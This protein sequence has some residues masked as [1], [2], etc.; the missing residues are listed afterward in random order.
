MK[1]T[2]ESVFFVIV[3]LVFIVVLPLMWLRRL[4]ITRNKKLAADSAIAEELYKQSLRQPDYAAFAAHYGCQPPPPLQQLYENADSN[5]EGDFELYLP[6]FPKPFFIAYFMGIG[7]ENMSIVRPGTEGFFPFA[8]DGCGNR[9][10]VNPREADP[11]V[12]LYDHEIHKRESLDV[13][14]SKF[15]AAKR[16]KADRWWR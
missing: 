3:V 6:S 9:Y 13:T 12:Y 10:I 1:E 11:I 7:N 4:R 16:T 5:L 2:V 8:N 14:L 15:L